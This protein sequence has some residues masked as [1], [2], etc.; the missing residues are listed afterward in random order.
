VVVIGIFVLVAGQDIS[1]AQAE[2]AKTTKNAL[3]MEQRGE[4]SRVITRVPPGKTV[5]VIARE[6]RWVKVRYQGRTG[7][8]TRT[9][10]TA[11]TAVRSTPRRGFVEG[12]T[13][14]RDFSGSGPGDRVGADTVESDGNDTGANSEGASEGA[15][16]EGEDE[17]EA[18]P[19][20]TA[21]TDA[22]EGKASPDNGEDG[23]DG[24]DGEDGEDEIDESDIYE[25]NSNQVVL[26]KA[27]SAELYR[28]PTSRST[29]IRS[30]VQGTRLVVLKRSTNGEWFLVEN[31]G[32][33][34]GW[35]RS[36][37]VG[38]LDF[39]YP[40]MLIRTGAHLGYTRLSQSFASD[41]LAELANYD[42]ATGA[43]SMAAGGD[44]L[45]QVTPVIMLDIDLTYTGTYSS[46]G[47]H[48]DGQLGPT[49]IAFMTH[50]INAG[51]AGGYNFNSKTGMVAYI[52]AG[53][54]Y[55]TFRIQDYNDPAVNRPK[56][57]SEILQGPTFGA[58]L[59]IPHLSGKMGMRIGGDV[60]PVLASRVQTAGFQDGALDSAF[61]AWG[62]AR[63]TYQLSSQLSVEA[64]Y[65]YAYAKT[66]WT[67]PS[68]RNT[69]GAL[70]ES[71]R[72]DMT[73]L[74]SAGVGAAF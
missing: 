49:D 42:I 65:R 23:E 16:D 20:R 72:R 59:D 45:Y 44:F 22:P 62:A 7:W 41:G 14:K 56:L 55:N 60:L 35:I 50:E 58:H 1:T 13:K 61:A 51:A 5:K 28:R 25:D 27:L 57:P 15:D 24:G 64:G 66:A 52:R 12:R 6:G 32:G 48:Y 70:L 63:L 67:G 38:G 47:I 33:D 69:T 36:S 46:P 17:A 74:L 53:Y 40:K 43:A 54:H 9:S 11:T 31:T 3:V 29:A 30:E 26:V 19:T 73:H 21:V 68:Q 18:G 10:L 39:S 37:M 71:S 4:K 2:V 34:Q 8:V